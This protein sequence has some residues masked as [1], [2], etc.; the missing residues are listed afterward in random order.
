M[1]PFPSAVQIG[2]L[3]PPARGEALSPITKPSMSKSKSAVTFRGFAAGGRHGVK[4]CSREFVIRF[5]D[6]ARG[7]INLRAVL[8]PNRIV[9]IEAAGSELARFDFLLRALWHGHDPDMSRMLRIDVTFV[10]LSIHRARD[11]AHVA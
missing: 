10:V 2:L 6:P 4:I 1:S 3:D 5:V 11:H 7:E 9:F 8:R